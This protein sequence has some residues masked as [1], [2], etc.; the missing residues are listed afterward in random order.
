MFAEAGTCQLEFEYLAK[1]TGNGTYYDK[2]RSVDFFSMTRVLMAR[3]LSVSWRCYTESA[4]MTDYS[5]RA[6]TSLETTAH[7]LETVRFLVYALPDSGTNDAI[8]QGHVSIGGAGDS[9]F[10]YLLKQYLING[11][12]K[13]LKQCARFSLPLACFVNLT[14]LIDS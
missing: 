14:C 2:V 11:D 13:A 4:R 7:L 5:P 3:R 12:V 9:A 6:S 8:A 1:L 10:E